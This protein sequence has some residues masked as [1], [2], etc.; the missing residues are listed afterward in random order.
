MFKAFRSIA[1]NTPFFKPNVY[2]YHSPHLY[3]KHLAELNMRAVRR[4][5]LNRAVLNQAKDIIHAE[6]RKPSDYVLKLKQ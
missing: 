4:N 5:F 3:T 2:F 6:V 1:L